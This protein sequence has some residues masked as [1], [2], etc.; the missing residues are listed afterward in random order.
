[1]VPIALVEDERDAVGLAKAAI[2]KADPVAFDKLRRCGRM[3]V[4]GPSKS[5]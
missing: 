4:L 1:M 3:R 2:S 5:S